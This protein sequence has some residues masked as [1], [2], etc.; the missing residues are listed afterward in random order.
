MET[1]TRALGFGLCSRIM[2]VGILFGCIVSTLA[3]AGDKLTDSSDLTPS[4][5]TPSNQASNDLTHVDTPIPQKHA[6]VYDAAK[7]GSAE[8][9]FE[10]GL[11]FEYGRDVN[12]DDARALKWYK[13][14][15]AQEF[16]NAQYRL[17]VLSDNGW[18]TPLDKEKAF[19]LYESAAENGHELAQHDVAIMYFEGEGVTKNRIQA[20]KWLKI[21]IANGS[22]LMQKHLNMVML[23][24]SS[25][26]I[27]VAEHL[28]NEWVESSE[29]I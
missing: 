27:G 13:K 24:M 6:A 23:E 10:L 21:A 26:E 29:G 3:Y 2:K 15:A 5:L 20:Y 18:G 25:D 19:K 1:N 11:L 16:S 8:A 7:N 9:Q 17:A 12:Q 4:D 14:S 28:A 22:E